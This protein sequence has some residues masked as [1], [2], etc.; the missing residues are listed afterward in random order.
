MKCNKLAPVAVAAAGITLSSCCVTE[1][2]NENQDTTPSTGDISEV[3]Q[4]SQQ[5]AFPF[6]RDTDAAIDL[7]EIRAIANSF[8]KQGECVVT[9]NI[10]LT[11]ENGK[12]IMDK[13]II[14]C[15][16]GARNNSIGE[17]GYVYQQTQYRDPDTGGVVADVQTGAYRPD[18]NSPQYNVS[19]AWSLSAGKAPQVR[20]TIATPDGY[21]CV[22][23][24]NGTLTNG[25]PNTCDTLLQSFR[26]ELD[27]AFKEH[28]ESTGAQLTIPKP[29]A[30]FL[31]SLNNSRN[32]S[33]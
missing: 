16:N 11:D 26:K 33:Q 19:F 28:Q 1:D 13:T 23:E 14:N 2:L 25:N 30:E 31:E 3:V 21:R 22:F 20:E 12:H 10:P 32:A 6:G 7:A 27:D 8:A 4:V 17:T 15:T 29:S 5:S 18:A 24:N 9:E